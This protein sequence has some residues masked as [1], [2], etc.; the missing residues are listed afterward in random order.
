MRSWKQEE[1]PLSRRDDAVLLQP[2]EPLELVREEQDETSPSVVDSK[3]LLLDPAAQSTLNVESEK[4][5]DLTANPIEWMAT[6][7]PVQ[8]HE[9]SEAVPGWDDP[10]PGADDTPDDTP[11]DTIDKGE[12]S[13]HPEA[14]AEAPAQAP[15]Q[16]LPEA[17]TQVPAQVSTSPDTTPPHTTVEDKPS[18]SPPPAFTAVAP[19]KAQPK[20]SAEDTARS[21]PR[22][23]WVDLTTSLQAS[24]SE[25]VTRQVKS[26][27][28]LA[29]QPPLMA[30]GNSQPVLA[31]PNPAHDAPPDAVLV[32]TVV[33]RVLEKMRPQVVDIITKEFLRPIVQALVNREIE[34]L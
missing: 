30:S 22:Q 7:P 25:L 9:A 15:A 2:I 21:I 10:I 27:A 12:S 1:D 17:P 14:P 32:E 20:Q 34:K 18:V 11:D 26:A 3:S 8:S 28:A 29:E 5:I 19:P 24:A 13:E 6:A 4:A 23:D 31:S 33:Q 16:I